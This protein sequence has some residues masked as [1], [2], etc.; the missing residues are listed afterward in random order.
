MSVSLPSLYVV[1]LGQSNAA[2][3]SKL[4]ADGVAGQ[5][6]LLHTIA[7]AGIFDRV[8][9]SNYA[10][11]SSPADM[12]RI[13][14]SS[15]PN[16]GWWHLDT[17]EPAPSLVH[18]VDA[19]RADI[20][21]QGLDVHTD[22]ISVV[23][24][25]GESDAS[26]I[27]LQLTDSGRYIQSTK[28][29]FEYLRQE[30][31]ENLD[32]FMIKTGWLGAEP[33]VSA[34]T[35]KGM[36]EPLTQI[37]QAQVSIDNELD[38]VH[39]AADYAGRDM[40]DRWHYQDAVYDE[41]GIEV[42]HVML[43]NFQQSMPKMVVGTNA[44][45]VLIGDDNADIF[46]GKLGDDTLLGA[47]GDDVYW[48]DNTSI[49]QGFDVMDGGAGRDQVLASA[50]NTY[51]ALKDFSGIEEFSANNYRGVQ[52]RGDS[53]S[54]YWDFTSIILKNITAIGAGNRADTIIGSTAHDIIKGYGGNDDLVGGLGND[55][56]FGGLGADTL[57]GDEGRD[58]LTG[59]DGAD[60]FTFLALTDSTA[61]ARDSI[62]DFV[63]GEDKIDVR[64][65]GFDGLQGQGA[66][67]AHELR[68]S[69]SAATDRTYVKDTAASGFE[70]FLSGDHRLD[71]TE[72]DFLFV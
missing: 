9:V 23:W 20:R 5:E 72:S 12:D 15:A 7:D 41:I 8:S 30:V 17:N 70:F 33:Y 63:H 42:A 52:I 68:L 1:V 43:D 36:H 59:G 60:V 71:L 65:L 11:P 51:I 38:Y 53:T 27:R 46:Y 31:S 29:I 28:A 47:A 2:Y 67:G 24:S 26:G 55:K 4:G 6:H 61:T 32:I 45:D 18:A 10:V 34:A 44:N 57:H 62:T 22:H 14:L 64:G 16:K 40:I 13:A 58:L 19:I 37:H 25:Q 56:L 35:A 54:H 66:A 69:Y 21:R 48:C 39:I 3:L 49:Y 50:D